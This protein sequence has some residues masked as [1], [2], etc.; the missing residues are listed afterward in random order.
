MELGLGDVDGLA[1]Q[2]RRVRE[3][4]V[5]VGAHLDVHPHRERRRVLRQQQARERLLL[6]VEGERA[7]LLGAACTGHKVER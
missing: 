7:D 6:G 1:E 3:K 2:L 4:G 5:T